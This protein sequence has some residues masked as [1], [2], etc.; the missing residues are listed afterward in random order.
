MRP[1][2][3]LHKPVYS[4]QASIGQVPLKAKHA[5][6]IF[7][8]RLLD[9][10]SLII[11][12]WGGYSG[13]K[14]GLVLEIF[15]IGAL[16]LAVLGSIRLLGSAVA[17]CTQWY[18]DQRGLL[19]YVAFLLLFVT[20]FIAITLVGRCFKALTKPT[21]VDS[22]DKLLGSILGIFKWGM[23]SS[24]FLWLGGLVQ[25]KIPEAH[26]EGTFLFPIIVSLCPQLLAWCAAWIPS[27]QEWLI[28]TDT[29]QND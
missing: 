14:R 22:L 28:T 29:L 19:P 11:L 6:K 13:F 27:I 21:L 26:T 25:L 18:Y 23:G 16:V 24:A 2:L 1:L 9:I 15:S 17:L 20:I 4:L 8:L 7:V 10:F 3:C 5:T 12:A